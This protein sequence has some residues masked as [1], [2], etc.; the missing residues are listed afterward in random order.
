MGDDRPY[1]ILSHGEPTGIVE[2]PIDWS[3]DDWVHFQIDWDYPL[4][5]TRDPAQVLAIWKGEFDAIRQEGG[6]FVLTMHPQ[7][8]G[9]PGRIAMLEQLIE[10]IESGGDA[11]FASLGDI[12]AAATLIE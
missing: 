7:V 10:H 11:W 6:V 12:A 5:A 4:Q 2:L 8:I 1:E 9:R 3:L